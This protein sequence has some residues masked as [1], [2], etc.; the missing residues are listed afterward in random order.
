MKLEWWGQRKADDGIGELLLAEQRWELATGGKPKLKF[1]LKM[2]YDAPA[3]FKFAFQPHPPE[4]W[5][6][7]HGPPH[8]PLDFFFT[9]C[10]SF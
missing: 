1:L 6:F 8:L 3:G 5:D 7:R 4:Y 2:P 10:V 9:F